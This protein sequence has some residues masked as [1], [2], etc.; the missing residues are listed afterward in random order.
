MNTTAKRFVFGVMM[1]LTVWGIYLAVGATGMFIQDSMVD[2]RK[3]LIVVVFVAL[4]LGL[5][6][7][8]L[9]GLKSKS[10]AGETLSQSSGAPWSRSGLTTAGTL[11]LGSGFWLASAFSFSVE[12]LTATTVLGWL[13]ALSFTVSASFGMVALSSKQ[14]LKG[15]WLGALGLLGFLVAFVVFVARMTPQA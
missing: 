9:Y 1:A 3:S 6:A 11:L 15:K 13:A 5:W 14:R 12:Y 7:I 8:V 2:G 4:F 10:Q